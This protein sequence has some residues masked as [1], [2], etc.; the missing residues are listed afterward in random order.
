VKA[1]V[2]SG[3]KIGEYLGRVA[4]RTTG[5]FNISATEIVQGISYKHCKI[6]HKKDGYSYAF[7]NLLVKPS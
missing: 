7:Q 6:I 2:T 5:S 4:V 1:I 3:K